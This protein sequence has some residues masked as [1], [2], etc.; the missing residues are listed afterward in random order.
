MATLV[1]CGGGG[2]SV[3]NLTPF[4]GTYTGTFSWS[5]YTDGALTQGPLTGSAL[6]TVDATGNVQFDMYIQPNPTYT[7]DRITGVVSALGA[8]SGTYAYGLKESNPTPVT[9]SQS[10]TFSLTG[11]TLTI[12]TVADQDAHVQYRTTMTLVR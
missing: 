9:F 7:I 10:S 4:T 6:G 3:T 11:N 1:A 8:C 2:S 12:A 5:R